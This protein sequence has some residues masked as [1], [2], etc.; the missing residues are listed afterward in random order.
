M[1]QICLRYF[2]F[3]FWPLWT[4]FL[5]ELGASWALLKPRALPFGF[6]NRDIA[7]SGELTVLSL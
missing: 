1:L 2:G 7:L 3:P 6:V 5:S 4:L